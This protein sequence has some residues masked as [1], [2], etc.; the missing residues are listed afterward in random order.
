M[1]AIQPSARET[2]SCGCTTGGLINASTIRTAALA[3]LGATSLAVRECTRTISVV[4][5]GAGE[6]RH[7]DDGHA[8]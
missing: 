5:D 2:N 1:R 7:R 6:A 8:G 4:A 3:P